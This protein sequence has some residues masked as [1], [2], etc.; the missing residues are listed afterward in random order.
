MRFA[1]NHGRFRSRNLCAHRS[2]QVGKGR[3][4]EAPARC[5]VALSILYLVTPGL[6]P[7][8]RTGEQVWSAMPYQTYLKQSRHHFAD[9]PEGDTSTR[10]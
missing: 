8:A 1:N 3:P 5:L 2:R 4:D 9:G 7:A 6:A 10:R